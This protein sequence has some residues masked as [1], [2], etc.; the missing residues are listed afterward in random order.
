[1]YFL[2][3]PEAPARMSRLA[4]AVRELCLHLPGAVGLVKLDGRQSEVRSGGFI[5]AREAACLPD[6]AGGFGVC[7]EVVA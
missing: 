3:T 1:M 6:G 5:N 4:R 7:G 2:L